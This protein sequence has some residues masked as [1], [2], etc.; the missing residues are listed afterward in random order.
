MEDRDAIGE[1]IP[2]FKT[3]LRLME[4]TGDDVLNRG[5]EGQTGSRHGLDERKSMTRRMKR[6]KRARIPGFLLILMNQ[7]GTRMCM[8]LLLSVPWFHSTGIRACCEEDLRY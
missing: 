2:S 7:L 3:W 4:G 6:R 5:E 8:V 1:P